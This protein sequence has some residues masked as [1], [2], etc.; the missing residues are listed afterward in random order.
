MSAHRYVE[1]IGSDAV[2]ATKRLAGVAPE[3]DCVC[4]THMPLSSTNKAAHSGF[5]T[6]RRHHQ[7]SKQDY[8]RPHKKDLHQIIDSAKMSGIG[9]PP[10]D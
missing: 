8:Q 10:P 5:E 6:Q 3:V 1:E 2:L 9:A 4:V 7:K